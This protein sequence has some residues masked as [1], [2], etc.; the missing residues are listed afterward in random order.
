LDAQNETGLEIKLKEKYLEY[1]NKSKASNESIERQFLKKQFEIHEPHTASE[2][3][4]DR[5][6][7]WIKIFFMSVKKSQNLEE[8]TTAPINYPKK[9]Y[10]RLR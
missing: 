9:E 3:A 2:H 6:K 5:L 7:F 1:F 10:Q 8:A 4:S